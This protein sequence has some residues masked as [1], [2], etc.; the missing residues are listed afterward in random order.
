MV[1]TAGSKVKQSRKLVAVDSNGKPGGNI[2]HI[3]DY[4][5]ATKFR[6]DRNDD[7]YVHALFVHTTQTVWKDKLG[8][9]DDEDSNEAKLQKVAQVLA[10]APQIEKEIP[11]G[12]GPPSPAGG[13]NRAA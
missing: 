1:I 12:D 9:V 5:W 6:P 13:P 4:I 2:I 8:H 10:T 7:L 11:D 3:L